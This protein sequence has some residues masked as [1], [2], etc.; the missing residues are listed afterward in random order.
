[1]D[2]QGSR[3][4]AALPAP[5]GALKPVQSRYCVNKTPLPS[6]VSCSLEQDSNGTCH[7]L[8]LLKAVV[9]VKSRALSDWHLFVSH[10]CVFPALR[11]FVSAAALVL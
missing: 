5:V 4:P 10:S 6:R 11:Q 9:T 1:M 8:P 2:L 7:T 3:V